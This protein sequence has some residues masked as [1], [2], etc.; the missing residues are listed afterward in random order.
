MKRITK[1]GLLFVLSLLFSCV[2]M[3]AW[4]QQS[5]TAG[6]LSEAGPTFKVTPP[7]GGWMLIA[8]G[9]M[10]FTDPSNKTATSPVARRALVKKIAEEK[11][12]ALLLSG[13]VPLS[14]GVV[15]DYAVFREETAA[16]RAAGLKVFPAMGNHELRGT[17][18]VENWWNAFPELRGRRWYS[19][20]FG[21]AYFITVDSNLDLTPGSVQSAWVAKQLEN[22]PKGTQYVFVSL[23]H[24]PMADPIA[25]DSSHDVRP[26]E[27]A[28]AQQL[29]AAAKQISAKIIVAAGHIHAYERFERGGVVYLVSGG[30]GA[31][32][33]KIA[34]TPGDLYQDNVFPNFHY[35][36]FEN[37][38]AGLKAT[39][40]RLNENG[41]FVVGDSFTVGAKSAAA[42][43]K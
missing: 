32:Q 8:Y 22:L 37:G 5:A 7:A 39:M 16:W 28:L 9:D 23:H 10:R 34:R 18:G 13:D 11:P 43:A 26:N 25:G 4:A 14:G 42:G 21:N 6:L 3:A 36:K 40:Y 12:D 29:E 17:G 1:A 38:T 30:G 20:E 2:T 15:N 27:A 33:Y 19:V 24:P 41:S 31:A 35:V